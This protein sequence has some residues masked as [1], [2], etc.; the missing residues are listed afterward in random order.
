M[1]TDILY[2]FFDRIARMEFVLAQIYYTQLHG[3]DTLSAAT[4]LDLQNTYT[5]TSLS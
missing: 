1:D 4:K 2:N 5:H 3:I